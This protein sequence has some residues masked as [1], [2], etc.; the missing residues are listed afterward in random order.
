M[1]YFCYRCLIF[2]ELNK[3]MASLRYV[4]A[5]LFQWIV[6]SL[7]V[8]SALASVGWYS[9]KQAEPTPLM[10]PVSWAYL[11]DRI[12]ELYKEDTGA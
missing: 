1:V 7:I 4:R 9:A 6:V 11:Y 5:A 3:P 8:V 12:F 2:L 10:K